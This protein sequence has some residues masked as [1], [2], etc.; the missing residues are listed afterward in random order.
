M[1]LD[2]F[3]RRAVHAVGVLELDFK[4]VAC[5]VAIFQVLR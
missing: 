1:M 2:V 4:I 3:K 5:S